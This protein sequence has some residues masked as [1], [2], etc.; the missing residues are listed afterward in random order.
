MQSA[1]KPIRIDVSEGELDEVDEEELRDEAD[2]E[3]F[4]ALDARDG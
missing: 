2:E 3:L 4:A 1:Y